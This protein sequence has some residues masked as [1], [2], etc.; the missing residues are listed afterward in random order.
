MT[1]GSDIS[2]SGPYEQVAGPVKFE[3]RVLQKLAQ[4]CPTIS[5][6]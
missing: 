6:V 5:G 3:S 1:A 4:L 2:L